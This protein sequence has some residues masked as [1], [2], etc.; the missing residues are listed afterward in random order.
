MYT[1]Y[2]LDIPSALHVMDT[3]LKCIKGIAVGG[4]QAENL[5]FMSVLFL[6]ALPP[7]LLGPTL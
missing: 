3:L 6:L 7:A 4:F 5:C 2:H 1:N